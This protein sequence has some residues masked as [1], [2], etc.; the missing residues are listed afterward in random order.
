MLNTTLICTGNPETGL[1]YFSAAP[2]L[3]WRSQQNLQIWAVRVLGTWMLI[4]FV[5]RCFGSTIVKVIGNQVSL[6]S[7]VSALASEASGWQGGAQGSTRP[8]WGRGL[9]AAGQWRQADSSPMW[10]L[11]YGIW[12]RFKRLSQE[13]QGALKCL[14]WRLTSLASSQSPTTLSL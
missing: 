7:W 3:L 14:G 2:A 5:L 6:Q 13:E 11:S 10:V 12:Q 9:G 4:D 1:A 8:C